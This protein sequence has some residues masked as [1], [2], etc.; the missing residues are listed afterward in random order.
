MMLLG[1]GDRLVRAA[2]DLPSPVHLFVHLRGTYRLGVFGT[3]IRM[4]VLFIGSVIGFTLMM[5]EPGAD[6]AL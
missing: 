6:R 2:A 4:V 5:V 1:S 3:L